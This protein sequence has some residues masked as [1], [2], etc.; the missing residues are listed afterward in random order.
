MQRMV[1]MDAFRGL[2]ILM[3]FFL[4]ANVIV[5]LISEDFV[6]SNIISEIN[7]ILSPFRMPTLMF[8]SGFLFYKSYKKGA[9]IFFKGK[10]NNI[11]WPYIVWTPITLLVMDQLTF[12]NIVLSPLFPPTFLWFLWF[13]FAYYCL[14][15]IIEKVKIPYVPVF[16]TSILIVIFAP[17]FA[18]IPRFFFLFIFFLF[19]H[20]FN[21]YKLYANLNFK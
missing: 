6:G 19:G 14:V 7:K 18:R 1:W 5:F 4:H 20:L 3:I 2:C 15:Y 13:L 16:I 8:L 11:L 10:F 17:D 9:K 21:K 12:K